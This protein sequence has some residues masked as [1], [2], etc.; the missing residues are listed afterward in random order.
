[1]GTK[2]TVLQIS[3]NTQDLYFLVRLPVRRDVLDRQWQACPKLSNRTPFCLKML[4]VL[5]SK[6]QSQYSD[7]L[8]VGRPGFDS[9]ECKIFRHS[10]QTD[11][12]AHPVSYLMGALSSGLNRQGRE[13]DRSPPS[14]AAVKEKRSYI[15]IPP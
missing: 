11:S 14:S 12:G 6:N 9:R 10:V 2:I 7:G 4:A 13:A 1:V 15:S 3:L 8:R 5:I